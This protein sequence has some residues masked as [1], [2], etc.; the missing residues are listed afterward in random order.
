MATAK[1]HLIFIS[2]YSV[3][4]LMTFSV[5]KEAPSEEALTPEAGELIMHVGL[6]ISEGS[7]LMGSDQPANMDPVNSGNNITI[8][9][10]TT[11]DGETN[12][13]YNGLSA[14]G[15][16]VMPLEK[17]FW[18]ARFGMLIDRFGIPWMINQ[19]LNQE[20]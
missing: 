16:I 18:G 11:S 6:P 17:T 14:G 15:K 3:V 9:I 20:K 1:K 13:L 4:S 8:S 7:V 19:S 2:Q 10:Q 12:R 5:S